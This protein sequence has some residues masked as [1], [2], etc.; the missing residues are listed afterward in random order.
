MSAPLRRARNA[1]VLALAAG[2]V[3]GC[4]ARR[5]SPA[6]HE[7]A[8]ESPGSLAGSTPAV[9]QSRNLPA[10]S[11]TVAQRL[12]ASPRH[13]EWAMV[14]TGGGDSVRA[15]VVYPE[16]ST[17]APVVLVIHEI[18]GM[19]TWIRGVADQLAA[20]GYIAI[21]P[22]L[23]TG[24]VA[25]EAD[26]VTQAAAV[27]A[28]RTLRAEDIQ[29]QLEAVARYGMSLPAALPKYGVVGFCWGGG[30]SF[31]HAVQ[32]PEGLAAAVVYYG[33]SPS[34]TDLQ[35]V[36]APVLG[37]YGGDDARV[38]AT[39]PPADSVMKA[40]GK[41]YEPHIFPGAGHGFLRA[42]DGKDGA[43]LR[44]TEQAWPMTISFY[45]KYLGA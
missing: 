33:T 2:V 43:N 10:G 36:R 16:R 5:L 42:Q 14:G 15:W 19:S 45:R 27:A 28:I 32:S 40:L 20:D 35:R 34:N 30:M 13:G 4:T 25:L 41:V 11:A 37:L 39:I 17:R 7:H 9:S 44:A 1:A 23:L 22:D 24:K 18:Y 26:T 6:T 12:A 31:A 8:M 21:A 3:L 29:R 38:D